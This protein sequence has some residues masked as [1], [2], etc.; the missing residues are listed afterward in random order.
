MASTRRRVPEP[1]GTARGRPLLSA[2]A[3]REVL[4]RHPAAL[5]YWIGYSGGLDSHVLLH[6]CAA[7]QR[8][9]PFPDFIAVH[10][11]HGLQ[12]AAD[13]WAGH[14]RQTCES[15]GIDFRLLRVDGR[16]ERGQSPEEAARTAR[17]QAIRALISPG[18]ILLTAQHR[19]DQ[20]ETL[21]LQLLRGAGLAGLSAMPECAAFPPGRLLRPLLEHSRLE[22]Q[23]YA[24][25]QRLRWIEDPS[26]QDLDFDRNFIRRRV[27]PLLTERWPGASET[28]SRSARHCAEAQTSLAALAADLLRAALINGGRSL[29]AARLRSYTEPDRR[30]VLREWITSAGF[31]VPSTRLLAQGLREL[32]DAGEDRHPRL[33][34]SEGQIRRYRDELFLLPVAGA[35]DAS[36]VL[37]WDGAQPLALPD[38]NGELRAEVRTAFGIRPEAWRTGAVTIRYRRGGE[39]LRPPG[40]GGTHELKKLFQEAGLP[41]WVR[42]RMP[43]IHIDGRLAAV[44]GLWLAAEFAGKGESENIRVHWRPPAWLAASAAL[45]E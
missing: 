17:Y 14:C 8:E 10:V 43:L 1:R 44:A 39:T 22:L 3:L 21:L 24:E 23:D 27:M 29:S 13:A 12:A 40:R 38:D 4:A 41:P 25:A 5:R 26:N 20:A 31:R 7:L 11:H 16:A 15:L 6:L 19:D 34:W 9:P 2:D 33:Y 28:L 30:L 35:F 45:A 36:A 42:E 18:E 37:N 32:L